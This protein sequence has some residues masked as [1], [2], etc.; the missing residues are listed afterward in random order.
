[1]VLTISLTKGVS[2]K[3]ILINSSYNDEL[4]VALVDGAKLFDLDT[5]VTDRV[6]YKGSIFKA[7]VSRIEQSLNA[8]F[9]DFGSARHGFLPLRELSRKFYKKNSQGKSEC[10]LKEGQEILVQINKEERGTKGA[11][12]S[13]QI[14]IAGRFMVLIAN[15][16]KSG[17]ISRRI[18]GDERDDLKNQI[19]KLDIPEGMSVIIRTAGI[20]RSFEEL[21]NDLSY[22][23]SLWDDINATQASADSPQLI[24]KDDKLIV[25]VFRDIFRDDIE[26][27]LVDDKSVFEEAK[28]FAELVIPDQKDKVKLYDE[29]IPL[30][31]RYQIESQIE[32]AFQ[33]EISLPSGGSI[34]I[35]PTEAMT[36]IDINSARSTKGKDIEETALKTNLESAKEIA[37]QLRLR[38]VGGLIVIDFIDMLSEESQKKVENAFRRAVSS[39]R[40]RIQMASI[41]RFGLLEVSR[42][43]LKPSLNETYDIEHVLVRGPRSLG[44]SILR[45]VGEDV[46][47]D[48]TA[49]I[50]VYVP[51]DVASY[52]L[53][54]KRR[55]ILSIEDSTGVKILIIADPYKSRPYYKVLRIKDSE[56]KQKSSYELTPD[57]PKPDTDWRDNKSGSKLN[58]LVDATDHKKNHKS[59]G[60]IVSWIKSL[61]AS[62]QPKKSTK[63]KTPQK[64]R[65]QKGNYKKKNPN[66]SKSRPNR[67]P[68]TSKNAKKPPASKDVRKPSESKNTRK[69][70]ESKNTRKPSQSKNARKPSKP[71]PRKSKSDAGPNNT[72]KKAPPRKPVIKKDTSKKITGRQDIVKESKKM[73]EPPTRAL[74]DPR[75]N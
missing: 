68:P 69:P 71:I 44:Q 6:L 48:N 2:M 72:R 3:R 74:N 42:Q 58:P 38:D 50:Q 60:G 59:G 32:L 19:S 40:A 36:T 66:A 20:D 56:V 54:E 16:D 41:S 57:S 62:P 31:N 9:V 15:S 65:S 52:L 12:L 73:P 30:F 27:I 55:D 64:R 51:A 70:S 35:D 13:T 14:S 75:D 28:N 8:A 61:T 39:D 34:V 21:Q 4:R 24:Y 10:T 17:G 46:A 5:E 53:N 49:E 45:I 23:I 25:R 33:R 1:M 18:T 22:L 7:T 11:T 37:R 26:E 67:K 47:K 29:E 63:K 43:R